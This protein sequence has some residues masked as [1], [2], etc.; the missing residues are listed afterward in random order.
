MPA[1]SI[2]RW[3]TSSASDGVSLRV[4][5]GNC[6]TRMAVR[7]IKSTILPTRLRRHEF[8]VRMAMAQVGGGRRVGVCH[9]EIWR[10]LAAHR[11]RYDSELDAH[12]APERP[13][14]GLHAQHDGLS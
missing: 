7:I 14:A 8:P 4:E 2:S 12:R 11:Q 9:R 3:L 6:E 5:S 1:R 13:R 10:A